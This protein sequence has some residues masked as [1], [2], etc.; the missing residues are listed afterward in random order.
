MWKNS[1]LY[2]SFSALVLMMAGCHRQSEFG[3]GD[4]LPEAA[5]YGAEPLDLDFVMQ[6][7][8]NLVKTTKGAAEL[9]KSLEQLGIDRTGFEKLVKA[10]MELDEDEGDD[11]E[12]NPD[13]EAEAEDHVRI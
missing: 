11:E 13:P 7:D 1:F 12:R 4:T 8:P 2:I 9:D 5:A 3:N 10:V 6:H